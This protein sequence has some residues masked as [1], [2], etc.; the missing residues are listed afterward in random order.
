MLEQDHLEVLEDRLKSAFDRIETSLKSIVPTNEVERLARTLT[1]LQSV[2][3]QKDMDIAQLTDDLSTAR[4]QMHSTHRNGETDNATKELVKRQ[5]ETIKDM[6]GALE[7]AHAELAAQKT[8]QTPLDDLKDQIKNKGLLELM[9]EL[10]T[11]ALSGVTDPDVINRAMEAELDALKEA[12][13]ADLEELRA[14]IADLEP[15]LKEKRNA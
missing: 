10:R 9:E 13:A 4:A 8:E 15:I 5:A 12:R 1:E 2:V 14:L 11:S 6:Q 7:K 3:E